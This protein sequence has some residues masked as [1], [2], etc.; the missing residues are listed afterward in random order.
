MR[1]VAET[2]DE[3]G[4]RSCKDDITAVRSNG[5]ADTT[6]VASIRTGAIDR[7]QPRCLRKQIADIKIIAMNGHSRH[8]I[9]GKA[10]KKNIAP[11]GRE[12]GD[13]R[14]TISTPPSPAVYPH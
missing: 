1:A 9:G 10:F 2:I 12:V 13:V 4:G 11:I 14:V 8:Q 6:A 5:S 3:S 7:D